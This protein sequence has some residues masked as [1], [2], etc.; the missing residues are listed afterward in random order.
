MGVAKDLLEKK[1]NKGR[2]LRGVMI[3]RLVTKSPWLFHYVDNFFY[4]DET[5]DKSRYDIMMEYIEF[6]EKRIESGGKLLYIFIPCSNNQ[7]FS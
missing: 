1:S 4:E 6:C 3:G 2:Q 7:V 5:P